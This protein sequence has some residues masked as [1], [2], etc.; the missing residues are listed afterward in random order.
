MNFFLVKF[1]FFFEYLKYNW[2]GQ[3]LMYEQLF[4]N[5]KHVLQGMKKKNMTVIVEKKKIIKK[6]LSSV[7]WVLRIVI[8]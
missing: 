8:K 2:F 7:E 1:F 5:I 3:K 6:V 4:Y